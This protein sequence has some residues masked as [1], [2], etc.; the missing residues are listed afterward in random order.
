MIRKNVSLLVTAVFLMQMIV[1]VGVSAESSF[2]LSPPTKIDNNN[3]NIVL[4]CKNDIIR[5]SLFVYHLDAFERRPKKEIAEAYG[6]AL[7]AFPHI[8]FDLE[9]IDLGKKGW[10]RYYPV[11]VGNE[12]LIVRIFL[13]EE[14]FFQPDVQVL[15]EILIKKLG[16][17]VQ[18]LPGINEMLKNHPIG[19]IDTRPDLETARSV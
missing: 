2:L 8:V 13:S 18:I 6:A 17:T 16:V 10:T 11:S 9:H 19:P 1:L 5:A 12:H 15:E 4:M 14:R 3:P 7:S